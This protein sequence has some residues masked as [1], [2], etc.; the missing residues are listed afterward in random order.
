M[1]SSGEIQLG[2][3]VF[4]P[5]SRDVGH[6]PHLNTQNYTQYVAQIIKGAIILKHLPK[7]KVTFIWFQN[8]LEPDRLYS[9]MTRK[10]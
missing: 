8:I 7:L 10:L 6:H 4:S 2:T 5:K 1:D 3:E 9:A